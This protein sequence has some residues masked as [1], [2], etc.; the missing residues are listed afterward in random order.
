LNRFDD[1]TPLVFNLLS[2][3]KEDN[4][5]LISINPN[6]AIDNFTLDISSL[7]SLEGEIELEILDVSGKIVL[8]KKLSNAERNHTIS[9]IG[10][11]PSTYVVK[12]IQNDKVYTKSLIKI[13]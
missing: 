11:T 3:T 1:K 7:T 13:E 5:N 9:L 12:V 2:S 6:P 4:I 8:E 10:L